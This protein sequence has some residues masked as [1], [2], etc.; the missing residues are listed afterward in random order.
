MTLAPRSLLIPAGTTANIFGFV[1]GVV[2]QPVQPQN[3]CYCAKC[4]QGCAL[5]ATVRDIV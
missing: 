2:K 1:I 5:G 4:A 3:L